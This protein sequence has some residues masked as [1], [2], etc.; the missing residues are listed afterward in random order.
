MSL[1]TPDRLARVQAVMRSGFWGACA[2]VLWGTLADTDGLTGGLWDKGLHFTAFYVLAVMGAI[3]YPA[4][5]LR[6]IGLALLLF[7]LAIE[8]VQM[9]VGRDSSWADFFADG[10]GVGLALAPIALERL[11]RQLM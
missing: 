6:W 5:R 9:L 7:G 3:A 1:L 8:A 2:V 11:R 10:L 4:L